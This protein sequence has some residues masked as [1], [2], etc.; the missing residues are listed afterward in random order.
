MSGYAHH[1][2]DRVEW[3]WG[4]GTGSGEITERFTEKVTRTLKGSDVTRDASEGEP[5][6]LIEQEDGDKVLKS[7]TEIRPI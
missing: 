4:T 6:Y 1:I 2:G 5:A 3:D 7:C